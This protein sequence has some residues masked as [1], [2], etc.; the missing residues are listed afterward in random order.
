MFAGNERTTADQGTYATDLFEREAIRF[1]ARAAS[2]RGSCI[3]AS[4]RRTARR[5]SAR[6]R[7]NPKSRSGV[8]APEKFLAMYADSQV[9]EKL[10]PYYAAVT[11][12]DDAIGRVLAAVA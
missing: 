2:S 1:I 11:C 4:T 6:T 10:R 5:A 7:A 3:S 9:P 12:M 8:Q